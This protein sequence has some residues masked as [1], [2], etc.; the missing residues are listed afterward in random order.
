[1]IS[2]GHTKLTRIVSGLSNSMIARNA[3]SRR[4]INSVA[5]NTNILR[6]CIGG[7]PKFVGETRLL[8]GAYDIAAKIGGKIV[9]TPSGINCDGA[10]IDDTYFPVLDFVPQKGIELNYDEQQAFEEIRTSFY[11]KIREKDPYIGKEYYRAR[12]L[13]KATILGSL[14]A[15][16]YM[17]LN[18]I[19]AS[20]AANMLQI[21]LSATWFVPSLYFLSQSFI[22]HSTRLKTFSIRN[23]FSEVEEKDESALRLAKNQPLSLTVV[24]AHM[25]DPEL[26]RRSLLSHCLQNYG[27][28]EAMLLLGNDV[29]SQ[30][31]TIQANTA[32]VKEMME[33]LKIDLA[34]QESKIRQLYNS[35]KAKQ[36]NHIED[37]QEEL[38]KLADL[39]S[40]MSEW[41]RS[42][43]EEIQSSSTSYPT[44]EFLVE[45]V[46]VRQACDFKEQ[47][48]KLRG[49]S[50]LL[51]EGEIS[52]EKVGEYYSQV[53]QSY[54]E[55]GRIFNVKLGLFMRTK[56]SNL[57]QEKT[58]AGNLTAFLSIL[59][60]KWLEETDSTGNKILVPSPAGKEFRAPKY[61]SVFDSDTIAKPN[62]LLRKIAFLEN[63]DNAEVGLIQSPYTIPTPEPTNAASASGIHSHWFLPMS[64]GY[65]AYN[66]A[67]WLGF[68]GVFR[69]D[70]LRKIHGSFIAETL[71]EDVET[72]LKLIRNGYKIV[73]SPE[74][75]CQTFSPPDMRGVQIQRERWASGGYRIATKILLRDCINGT[76]KSKD[77]KEI[78]LRFNYVLGLNLLPLAVTSTFLVEAPLHRE[79]FGIETIPFFLYLIT[80]AANLKETRYKIRHYLDGLAIS[81]FM[82]FYYLRGVS[83]SVKVFFRKEAGQVFK[84]TPRIKNTTTNQLGIFE[85]AGVFCLTPLMALKM[86]QDWDSGFY[87]DFYPEYQL[88]CILYGIHRLVGFQNFARSIKGNLKNLFI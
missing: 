70:A 51:Q 59:G 6:A 24:P 63:P 73:T 25:E 31:S 78:M 23:S 54:I 19:E 36:I 67:F 15:N 58:K 85:L 16:I 61:V 7:N 50:A 52:S 60:E 43:A 1:M 33:M 14:F 68:N 77:M 47:E 32:Q 2:A 41:F 86:I 82:N 55:Y 66:S 18:L 62:Y 40:K 45:Q 22:F 42:K 74:E 26:I 34:A 76:Y 44:D 88:F 13:F 35:F 27:N 75:Q 10:L 8:Y 81:F 56:Y 39:C 79:H 69:Y 80:Y 17:G 28:K 57:E 29:Y 83:R 72:S 84:A 9:I 5:D 20:S 12:G 48:E 87:Y 65:T 30:D 38:E 4:I 53:V 3:V 46:L 71:I 37:L 11:N 64:I 21:M 49:E